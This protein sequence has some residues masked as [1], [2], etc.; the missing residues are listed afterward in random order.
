MITNSTSA[1]L[2]TTYPNIVT[3]DNLIDVC[4]RE[5]DLVRDNKKHF[6]CLS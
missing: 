1:E 3:N 5:E 4:L 2:V 6:K